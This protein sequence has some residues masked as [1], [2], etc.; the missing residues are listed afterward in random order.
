MYDPE[1]LMFFFLSVSIF[2]IRASQ[3]LSN[4]SALQL[5]PSPYFRLFSISIRGE[6]QKGSGE[7]SCFGHHLYQSG[8]KM[9]LSSSAA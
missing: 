8:L 4:G 9:Q 1:P 2:L 7:Q 6:L 3:T 5:Y